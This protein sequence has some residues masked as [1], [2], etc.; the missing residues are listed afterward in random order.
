MKQNKGI[1]LKSTH[2]FLNVL[3][4]G[5]VHAKRI[6][7]LA[8]ATLGV[9]ST[10]SLAVNTIGQGLALARG[11]LPKHT[12]KQ[13][14][15]M[16]SNAGIN[17]DELSERWVPYVV[18]QRPHII[19]AMDWTDFDADNQATIMLSLISKHGRSTPLVWLTVDKATL[20]NHRNAYEYR[21]FGSL[22]APAFSIGRHQM[23]GGVRRSAGGQTPRFL[24]V[25]GLDAYNGTDLIALSRDKGVPQGAG[26]SA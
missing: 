4:S 6:Y 21:V 16:L 14:D 25:F 9:I 7:S 18:G 1:T 17:V 24:H 5:D 23:L 12:I 20:K 26:T 15:R 3:F 13:V 22:N 8:N 19:V 10:A 2:Q 11:R